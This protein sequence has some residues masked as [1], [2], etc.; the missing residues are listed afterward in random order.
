MYLRYTSAGYLLIAPEDDCRRVVDAMLAIGYAEEFCVA[1]DFSPEFVARLMEAGFLVMSMKIDEEE[2]GGK[3]DENPA[4]ILLPKLHLVR[5]ALFFEYQRIKRSIRRFLGR[6]E[7]RPNA[8]FDRILDRCVQVHGA[9]WLTPPLD[10][11]STGA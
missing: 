4:Y 9:D 11:D 6:Y 7:L 3:A 8:D 2:T 1:L 5:S 10:V